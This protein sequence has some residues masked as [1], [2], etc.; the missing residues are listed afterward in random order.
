MLLLCWFLC[1]CVMDSRVSKTM[2]DS[3]EN[4]TKVA[5]VPVHLCVSLGRP[6]L[7]RQ[8]KSLRLACRHRLNMIPARFHVCSSTATHSYKLLNTFPSCS[9]P[10]ARQEIRFGDLASNGQCH[11]E[12]GHMPASNTSGNNS[13][14]LGRI[15]RGMIRSSSSDQ[16]LKS[17]FL[18]LGYFHTVDVWWFASPAVQSFVLNLGCKITV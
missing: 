8:S 5:H 6:L 4:Q 3:N 9:V 10:S 14:R 7:S 15:N 18:P 2:K 17:F 12:L 11:R 16:R 13:R 1:L